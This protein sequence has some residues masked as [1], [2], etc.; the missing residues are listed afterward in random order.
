M[1]SCA[2]SLAAPAPP[3]WLGLLLMLLLG[4]LLGLLL[5][6]DEVKALYTH[7]HHTHRNNHTHHT[8][9]QPTHTH[10]PYTH[11]T[12]HI[13]TH[14][15]YTHTHHTFHSFRPRPSCLRPSVPH[16]PSAYTSSPSPCM[17]TRLR[18]CSYDL[19]P[20]TRYPLCICIVK[21]KVLHLPRF[22]LSSRATQSLLWIQQAALW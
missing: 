1:G 6:L 19:H 16:A 17:P 3:L 9:T 12:P 4:V 2:R 13:N 15:R 14:T 7:T 22:Y 8:H 11:T 20:R 5:G 21:H 10:T 18:G